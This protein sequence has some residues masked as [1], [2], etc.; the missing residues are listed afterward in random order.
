MKLVLAGFRA[1]DNH[2]HMVRELTPDEIADHERLTKVAVI[3]RDKFKLFRIFRRNFE[4]WD[5]YITT[6]LQ[7]KRFPDEN[8][9]ADRLMMNMLASGRALVDHFRQY[10]SRVHRGSAQEA[11][12]K[13]FVGRLVAKSWAFGFFQDYRNYAQHSGLPIGTFNKTVGLSSIKLTIQVD[14]EFLLKSSNRW[15][16]SKLKKEDGRLD[17]IDLSRRYY[18]R[19]TRDFGTFVAKAFSPHLLEAHEFFKK[20]SG[21]VASTTS[22]NHVF[23][24]VEPIKH[25][26]KGKKNITGRLPPSDL[27]GELGITFVPKVDVKSQTFPTA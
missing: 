13:A 14:A 8:L 20:L 2:L 16:Y 17:L 10:F 27:F 9:E 3:A 25:G 22:P 7:R 4:E 18:I 24:L 6:L 19:L 5:N 11:D 1:A 23:W 15:E 21:E 12:F 26:R